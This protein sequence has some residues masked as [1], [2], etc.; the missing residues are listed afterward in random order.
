MISRQTCWT[1]WNFNSVG[2]S[3]VV[4]VAERFHVRAPE[5][6]SRGGRVPLRLTIW[7]IAPRRIGVVGHAAVRIAR[8]LIPAPADVGR[9]RYRRRIPVERRAAVPEGRPNAD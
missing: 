4:A 3:S 5:T 8:E 9:G 1:F 7:P 2:R 6:L